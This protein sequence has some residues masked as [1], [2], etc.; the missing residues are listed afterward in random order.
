MSKKYF[1]KLKL[2]IPRPCQNLFTNGCK[3]DGSNLYKY[4]G[5]RFR[6]RLIPYLFLRMIPKLIFE[7][8]KLWIINVLSPNSPSSQKGFPWYLHQV[9]L[10][11]QW[12]SN[13]FP[14][15]FPRITIGNNTMCLCKDNFNVTFEDAFIY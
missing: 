10:M 15:I 13:V 9:L 3:F 12:I 1:Q 5:F 11:S 14:N 2:W 7:F 6:P 4:F 8:F